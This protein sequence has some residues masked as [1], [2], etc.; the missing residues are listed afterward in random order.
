MSRRL[1]KVQKIVKET[2]GVDIS[3]DLLEAIERAIER[4]MY[5]DV[6]RRS[7]LD[8]KIMKMKKRR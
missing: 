2:T 8:D 1:K 6:M 4:Q 7:K 3:I 5:E